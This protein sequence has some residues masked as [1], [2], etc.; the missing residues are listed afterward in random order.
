MVNFYN[1][2][3]AGLGFAGSAER[4]FDPLAT[5]EE[6]ERLR[7]AQLGIPDAAPLASSAAP[8][9]LADIPLTFPPAGSAMGLDF[10]EAIANQFDAQGRRIPMPTA[11]QS[12]A[13]SPFNAQAEPEGRAAAADAFV[14]ALIA[15]QNAPPNPAML[16][17]QPEA[18]AEGQPTAGGGAGFSQGS[19]FGQ[20]QPDGT[21]RAA[22]GAI[23]SP[24]GAI[25]SRGADTGQV[26]PQSFLR[27]GAGTATPGAQPAQPQEQA[28][29]LRPG[30]EQNDALIAS[31]LAGTATPAGYTDA[32]PEGIV[33]PIFGTLQDPLGRDYTL[34]QTGAGE[35][36]VWDPR[37]EQYYPAGDLEAQWSTAGQRRRLTGA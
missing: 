19:P 25:I 36:L 28:R 32:N 27:A 13:L 31:V 14:Q 15:Y 7:R 35:F 21:I 10:T 4:F 34:V 2:P 37:T 30:I 9:R 26:T 33:W 8:V 17:A 20:V 1:P 12:L 18:P 3:A 11:E 24:E 6:E 16:A 29:P 23:L 5:P 22:D